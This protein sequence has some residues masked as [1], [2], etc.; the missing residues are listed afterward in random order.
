SRDHVIC[1]EPRKI[2]EISS[3]HPLQPKDEHREIEDVE[4]DEYNEPGGLCG[5]LFEHPTCHF[6][7]PVMQPRKE[8]EPGA[9]EHR[10]MEMTHYKIG[11]VQVQIQGKCTDYQSG[12]SRD[13]KK[14]YEGEAV[15]EGG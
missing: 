9:A 15:E 13:R 3:W 8:P 12:Q 1:V 5:L 10:V 14:E 2:L 7:E 6:G 11:A 4:P